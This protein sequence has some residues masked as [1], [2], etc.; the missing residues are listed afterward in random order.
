M[1]RFGDISPTFKS[2]LQFFKVLFCIRQNVEPIMKEY[3]GQL[4]IVVIGPI[5]KSNLDIWTHYTTNERT[6]RGVESTNGFIDTEL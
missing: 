5:L 4:F 2:L 1:T 3:F 6:E